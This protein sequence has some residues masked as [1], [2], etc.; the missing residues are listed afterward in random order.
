MEAARLRTVQGRACPCL[1]IL[2]RPLFRSLDVAARNDL[3]A[4]SRNR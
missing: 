1:L 3:V 4:E 2:N